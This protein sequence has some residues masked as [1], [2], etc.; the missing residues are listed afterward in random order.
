MLNII[1]ENGKDW[2][3]A[4]RLRAIEMKQAGWKQ[5]DIARELGVTPG[6]ISQW[7]KR[8]RTEGVDALLHHRAP[9]RSSR[10]TSGQK[11]VLNRLLAKGAGHFGFLDG[12]WTRARVKEIIFREFGISYHPSHVGRLMRSYGFVL[13]RGQGGAEQSFGDRVPPVAGRA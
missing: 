5:R 6:A 2:G 10:L 11:E 3:E 7:V 4:R 13:H 12:Y 9:G 1:S 8:A